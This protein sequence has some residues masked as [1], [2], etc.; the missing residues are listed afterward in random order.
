MRD[1]LIIPAVRPCAQSPT[2]G[3][4]TN[5]RLREGW[6][7]RSAPGRLALAANTFVCGSAHSTMRERILKLQQIISSCEGVEVLCRRR[8]LLLAR[9][10]LGMVSKGCILQL[11]VGARP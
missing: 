10:M 5:Q 8:I 7:V 3:E 2:R 1:G 4:E 9:R 6:L 11:P